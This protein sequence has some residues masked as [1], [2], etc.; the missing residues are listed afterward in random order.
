MHITITILYT[1]L[2]QEKKFPYPQGKFTDLNPLIHYEKSWHK[3]I[4]EPVKANLKEEV[5]CIIPLACAL[6][7]LLI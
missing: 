4:Y 5:E 1:Q 7:L 6:S 3:L 2:F